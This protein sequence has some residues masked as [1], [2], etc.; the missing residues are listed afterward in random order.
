M[1]YLPPTGICSLYIIDETHFGARAEHYG[2]VLLNKKEASAENKRQMDGVDTLDDLNEAIKELKTSITI[3][4]SGTPYRILMGSE[5]EKEDII[6][7]VQFS[8][9][10]E[11]QS[12]WI[13]EHKYDEDT[14]EWD[15]PYFGFPQMIRFAF[16][17]N[18]A[19]LERIAQLKASGATSSFSELFKPQSLSASKPGFNRFVHED[20]VLDFLKVIEGIKNDTNVLGF[21]DNARIQEGKLC[22]HMVFVL[23]YCASCDAMEAL[24][25]EN[26]HIFSHLSQYEILNISGVKRSKRFNDT[27]YVK[28]LIA[29]CEANGKK[30]LTLTV[31]RM[32]T[33]NTVPQWDTMLFLKQSASPEEYDQAIFRLQNPFIDVYEDNGK[34]IKFNMKPQTI[35]VDFDPERV[36]RLQE[37]KSQ[38]Y[39]VNTDNNGNSYLRERIEKELRI[40]PIITLDHNKL[41]EVT[42]SNILDAVRNYGE[43]RSVLDEASEMPV[44][45][46]LLDNPVLRQA[47]SSLNEIDS[48]KGIVTNAYEKPSNE[49]GDDVNPTASSDTDDKSSSND[50]D[51]SEDS[52]ST[53][54]DDENSMAKKFASFYAL[55]LFF[56]FLTEDKIK[57]L[58]DIIGVMESSENNVRLSK[59]IGLSSDIL[60]FIQANCNGFALSKLDYKIENINSLNQ[61]DGKTPLERVELALTKFGRMSASE[62]V[63]PQNVADDM[64]C[65]LPENVFSLGPVLDIASKQGEF[66]IA[67]LNRFGNSVS[68]RI[69]AICTSKLAYEFT[70]KV[71]TLLSLPID[72]I[73]DSFTSYDLIKRDKEKNF[74]IP[75]ILK[76][77]NFSTVIGNPPYQEKGG[78][79]GTNDASI[80]QDF[81]HVS[82]EINPP[83]STL[84]I[85]S[86]WFTGG[87]ENL[88][89]DFRQKMLTSNHTS[90]MIAFTNAKELFP[91]AEIK[92]GCCYFVYSPLHFGECDYTLVRDGQ[93]FNENRNLG[94]FDV[95]VR[96]PK[97]ADIVAKVASKTNSTIERL[98]SSDTPFGIP[99]NPEISSKT[100]FPIYFTSNPKHNTLLYLIKKSG[101]CTAYVS[102]KDI[103]KN[104][105]DIDKHKIFIPEAYG[106][107]ESFPHQILGQPIYA[108]SNSVCSQSYLYAAF[109][110]E[111]EAKNF[112]KYIST[113]FL[114]ILVSAAKVSQHAMSKV[115]RFVPLQDFTANSDVDWSKPV[116]EIDKQLYAKY[117]LTKDEI[118]FIDS[119]IKPM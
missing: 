20:V 99:T 42:A 93:R 65:L 34:S 15:N 67:L 36:F 88:V 107:G 82:F 9:I 3:H 110:S 21:L 40:S 63:T 31:N 118:D 56:A 74:L 16:T 51:S 17:P 2:K 30:T 41:R 27:S 33:G 32:L 59:N 87:R 96:E 5:F 13:G 58:E 61:D 18:H 57:S 66:T 72:H 71:Y 119:M 114:R 64:V 19:S 75:Q 101:R 55:I 89:G 111:S 100:P 24:I 25:K 7:F 44:D 69:Y 105:C 23:P 39:N 70:R 38:I 83:F 80:Y 50:N 86:R 68:D 84:V 106:A 28:R 1:K 116:D 37:R 54:I 85:P 35:L 47:I 97:L 98:I 4:L 102:Q 104:T 92:G 43:T 113:R 49:E 14:P 91:N 48:K 117:G 8:D 6:A 52:N 81:C 62:I 22:R 60:K 11:A 115:Y 77:M 76:N 112:L 10:A 26:S 78:S 109:K 46:S 95:F 108:P 79:G 90:K 94:E 103:Q 73:F 45:F 29:E 53:E 12:K